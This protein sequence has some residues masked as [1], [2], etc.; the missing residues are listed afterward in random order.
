L[1]QNPTLR[2]NLTPSARQQELIE[3]ARRLALERFAPRAA[4][5]DRDATFPFDDYAD[6]RTEGFRY[7]EISEILGVSESTVCENLRRGLS[8]LIKDCHER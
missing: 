6:L 7:R 1:A 4:A 2:M 5:H 8:R 3:R